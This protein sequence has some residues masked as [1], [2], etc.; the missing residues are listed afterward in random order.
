MSQHRD[1]ACQKH[2]LPKSLQGTEDA[3]YIWNMIRERFPNAAP[4]LCEMEALVDRAE[5]L[6]QQLRTPCQHDI[7]NSTSFYTL[8]SEESSTLTSLNATSSTDND[9]TENDSKNVVQYSE[10]T[11]YDA[12]IDSNNQSGN[13]VSRGGKAEVQ[14]NE[15]FTERHSP[16]ETRCSAAN[17][18]DLPKSNTHAEQR[19]KEATSLEGWEKAVDD[20]MRRSRAAVCKDEVAQNKQPSKSKEHRQDS[21]SANEH[22]KTCVI[23]HQQDKSMDVGDST[24]QIDSEQTIASQEMVEVNDDSAT[25]SFKDRGDE[26]SSMNASQRTPLS[27]LEDY[28]KRCKTT[29]VYEIDGPMRDKFFVMRGSLCGYT[30]S[31]RSDCEE[32]AK[33]SLATKILE[34]IAN[35]QMDDERPGMLAYFTEEEYVPRA[36]KQ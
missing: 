28:A 8:N 33:N 10:A 25:N 35:R 5:D 18:S 4:L 15:S 31:V 19:V 17:K 36:V 7:E 12:D 13:S 20:T 24:V 26:G 9:N 14:S 32:S 22:D 21:S 27:I 11:I 16:T 1:S 34:M 30:T 6:L 23:L 2:D 29:V 3:E